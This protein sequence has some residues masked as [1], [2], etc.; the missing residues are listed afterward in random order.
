MQEFT[1]LDIQKRSNLKRETIRDWVNRGFITPSRTSQDSRGVKSF[2]DEWELHCVFL[3]RKMTDTGLS[4][5]F[6][7]RLVDSVRPMHPDVTQDIFRHRDFVVFTK[8]KSGEIKARFTNRHNTDSFRS[9]YDD[10]ED[11][12]VIFVFNFQKIREEIE[13]TFK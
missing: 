8:N 12:G 1:I 11:V 9:L 4:R 2:F 13:L 10:K 3:F 5:E 6:A 7:A